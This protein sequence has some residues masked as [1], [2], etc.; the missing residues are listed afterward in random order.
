MS[1]E[2]TTYLLDQKVHGTYR[3]ETAILGRGRLIEK[4][5]FE[6]EKFVS[7]SVLSNFFHFWLSF[8][9]RSFEKKMNFERKFE[10]KISRINVRKFLF[11]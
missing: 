10:P 7:K 5:S 1:T 3:Y 11:E 2:S 9:C 4:R 8:E 6:I